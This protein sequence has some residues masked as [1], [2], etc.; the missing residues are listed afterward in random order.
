MNGIVTVLDLPIRNNGRNSSHSFGDAAIVHREIF[1][2]KYFE[3]QC[4]Q[5]CT[6]LHITIIALVD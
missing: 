6:S 3:I 1:I 4:R 2:L 5:T